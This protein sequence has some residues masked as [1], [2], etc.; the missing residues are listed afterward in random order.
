MGSSPNHVHNT[1]NFIQQIKSIK[2]EED[3]CISSHDM[4]AL[5]TLVLIE[6]ALKIIKGKLEHDRELH[7]RTTMAAD[8]II[9]LL[10]L[11]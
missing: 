11:Y 2:L 8:K 7:Q 5:Y 6:P 9:S 10:E 3:E 4:K 1:R